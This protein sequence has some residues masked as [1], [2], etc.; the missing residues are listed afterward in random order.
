MSSLSVA[1]VQKFLVF[2]Y[3]TKFYKEH[4]SIATPDKFEITDAI[5][6][7]FCNFLSD[8]SYDYSTYTEKILTELRKVSEEEHYLEALEEDIKALEQKL[9]DDKAADLQKHRKEISELLKGEILTRYYYQ[10]GR[11]QGSLVSDP[12]VKKAVEILSNKEEYQKIVKG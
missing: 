5:Y 7:D 4:T 1:L 2:D 3:A 10:E 6:A 11:I 9:K 12:D 8:K